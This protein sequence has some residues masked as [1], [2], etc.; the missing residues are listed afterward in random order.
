[1]P[2]P[3]TGSGIEVLVY[4]DEGTAGR[5]AQNISAELSAV[6]WTDLGVKERPGLIVLRKT[7][8]DTLAFDYILPTTRR[9][10]DLHRLETC[11][12]GRT[13]KQHP[14]YFE[15]KIHRVLFDVFHVNEIH[16][17]FLMSGFRMD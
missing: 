5:L 15:K 6:G 17:S 4:S 9:I 7:R 3:Q 13:Q 12:A 11:A 1:M 2:L 8:L 16:S 14:V 10:P